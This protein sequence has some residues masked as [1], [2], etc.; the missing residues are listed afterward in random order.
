MRKTLTNVVADIVTKADN[1]TAAKVLETLNE[2]S[3]RYRFQA[4]FKRC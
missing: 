2:A 4:Y 1:D 3:D